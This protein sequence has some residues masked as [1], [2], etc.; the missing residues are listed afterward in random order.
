MEYIQNKPSCITNEQHNYIGGKEKPKF[1]LENYI[2]NKAEFKKK[3]FSTLF[4][5]CVLHKGIDYQF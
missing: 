2:L 3:F 1:T 5:R 4:Q